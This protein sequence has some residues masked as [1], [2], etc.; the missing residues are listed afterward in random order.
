MNR[1][2][3]VCVGAGY[4]AKFHV[5]AWKRIPEVS[6]VA[7]CDQKI[8]KAYR[9]AKEFEVNTV[10]ASIDEVYKNISFDIL[11]IITPPGSHLSLSLQAASYG[12]SIICQ[13]P[14]AP[15]FKEAKELVLEMNQSKV[16]FMVHENF[17]FQ[18]W[19]RQ[20][21]LLLEEGAI[22][23]EL[24]SINHR[25]RMGDGWAKTA[26]LDRQPYFRTM[27]RLLIHETGIHFIDV[28][29]F[30]L[31][32]VDSVYAR[33]RK[34]NKHIAGED[35]GIIFFEF[36]NGCQGVFDGNR[37]NEPRVANPRYTFGEMLIE[38]SEGSIR[39]Y[40]NG[41]IYLQK[42]GEREIEVEYHHEDIHFSGDCVFFT[43]KHFVHCLLSG[44]KFETNGNDYLNNL[45]VQEAIYVSAE[46]KKEIKIS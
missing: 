23:Q 19:Y 22:G 6:V 14:L 44:K 28:F 30:L 27:P 24:F 37:Y 35:S 3:V 12:K 21:K 17:R 10:Y 26:Y 1:L 32:E 36:K 15:S 29:R 8:E 42:L 45:Q 25:L 38:G 4:F 34:L 43:Q 11:D 18:P 41:A 39:L 5:E 2:R 31:G 16:R 20:I 9:L 40:T 46:G 33:L 7:I 13:K